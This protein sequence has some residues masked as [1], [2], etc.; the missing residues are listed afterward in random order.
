MTQTDSMAG[1]E[2]V[3]DPHGVS[4]ETFK[5]VDEKPDSNQRYRQR[6]RRPLV[7]DEVTGSRCKE[8]GV[9]CGAVL[10]RHE[11]RKR[12]CEGKYTET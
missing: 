2:A 1:W 11:S 5:C 3:N 6:R 7:C 10:E 12:S 8:K 9:W 4:G